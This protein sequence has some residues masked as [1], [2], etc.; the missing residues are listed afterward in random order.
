MLKRDSSV[1]QVPIN[2][3]TPVKKMKSNRMHDNRKGSIQPEIKQRD[4]DD[5]F[6]NSFTGKIDYQTD[7]V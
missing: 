2:T 5:I 3:G 7:K 1:D 4:R 6:G